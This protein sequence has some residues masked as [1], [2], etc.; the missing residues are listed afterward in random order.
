LQQE[1]D[2][3]YRGR[4][5]AFYDMAFNIAFAGGAALSVLFMPRSGHSLSLIVIV[6]A[7][8]AITA[9][10]YWLAARRGQLRSVGGSADADTP[11]A[12]T[13]G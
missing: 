7:G 10:C 2:D 12:G 11:L 9:A 8:F 6:A 5:F 3:A 4:M 1:A 13:P